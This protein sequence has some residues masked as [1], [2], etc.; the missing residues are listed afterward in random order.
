VVKPL[1]LQ[2]A[3]GTDL[4]LFVGLEH[5]CMTRGNARTAGSRPSLLREPGIVG[6]NTSASL[7]LQE[8]VGVLL[9]SLQ[10][11]QIAVVSF[12]AIP[13]SAK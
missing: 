12:M 9:E 1:N 6:G 10:C 11:V 2:A 4:S 8:I 13:S 3:L 5:R 7:G